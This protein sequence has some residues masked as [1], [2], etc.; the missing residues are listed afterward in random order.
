[1]RLRDRAAREK[2][3]DKIDADLLEQKKKATD[4]G[5][6]AQLVLGKEPGKVVVQAI[7]D[8]LMGLLMP[9]VRK[10]QQAED[11][12]EQSA[13]NLQIAFALAHF[14][15]DQGRYPARLDELA[16]T[17]LPAVANDVFSGKPLIYKPAEKGYLFYS[18]GANG[19]DDGGRWYDDDP[20]GDDPRVQMPLPELKK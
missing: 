1:M 7:G 6:L 2:E 12:S 15:A 8:V 18:V 20:P 11:R 19:Q 4:A 5:N 16:P 3:F 14:R 13:R 17:Y 9:A 10:V